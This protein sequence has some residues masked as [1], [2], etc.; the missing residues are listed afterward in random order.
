MAETSRPVCPEPPLVAGA[1]DDDDDLSVFED[2][3]AVEGRSAAA[4]TAAAAAVEKETSDASDDAKEEWRVALAEV[5]RCEQ[6]V[7]VRRSHLALL[8]GLVATSPALEKRSS[9][10]RSV[11][12]DLQGSFV[13]VGTAEKRL[14]AKMAEMLRLK[15]NLGSRRGA[16]Q[17]AALIWTAEWFAGC[18]AHTENWSERGR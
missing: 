13:D 17:A 1:D 15:E 10:R 9:T 4:A 6:L 11:E 2:D 5:A 8:E 16:P 18:A 12:R 3:E 7:A 14:D